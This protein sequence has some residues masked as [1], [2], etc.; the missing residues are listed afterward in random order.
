MTTV[1]TDTKPKYKPEE[2]MKA[3]SKAKMALM[4]MNNSFIASIALQMKHVISESVS[5]AA[6][7]G[8]SVY[9]NPDFFMSCSEKERVGLLAHEVWHPALL[10]FHRIGFRDPR[11]WNMAGDH[12]INLML[13]D[14]GFELP[15]GAL[16]DLKFKGM[17]TEEVYDYLEKDPNSQDP[18]FEEDILESPD[19]SGGSN[20][21]SSDYLDQI[22]DMVVK[23]VTEARMNEQAGLIPAEVNRQVDDLINPKLD[24][25]QLLN[26]FIDAYSNRDYSWKRPNKRFMPGYMPSVYSEDIEHIMFAIDT[27]GSV[28][29]DQLAAML[30]EIETVNDTFSPQRLTVVDCDYKIHNIFE[31]ETSSE[32]KSLEFTGGGGTSFDPVMRLAEDQ[33][34]TL[35]IYFT[36]LWAEHYTADAEWTVPT[37]WICYSDHEPQG[38]GDTVYCEI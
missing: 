6:T 17:S 12:V 1:A 23:A 15:E 34:P 29:D 38:Y 26:R 19:D 31:I 20:G 36:D 24:W 22:Q 10:H 4:L 25:R 13:I 14:H 16:K 35:L 32:I 37:L 21:P 11:V 8:I 9:Y 7:D 27:S 18:N 5:T 33:K 30:A 28:H 3:L 2:V